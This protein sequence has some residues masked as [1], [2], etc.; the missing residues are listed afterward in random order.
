MKYV[1]TITWAVLISFL[2]AYVLSSMAGETFSIAST[3][4]I[5]AIFSI[6]VILI[7]DVL[8]REKKSA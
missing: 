7:G 6:I 3:F 1:M 2:V 5:A 8:L 4:I